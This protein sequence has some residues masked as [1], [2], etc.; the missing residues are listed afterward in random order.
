VIFSKKFKG[1]SMGN[2]LSVAV[3]L[4]RKAGKTQLD[5]LG[6]VMTIERKGAINLVTEVDRMCEKQIFEGLQNAFPQHDVLGEEGIAKRSESEFRWIVDPLDGTT[7][8][9]HQFPFFGVSIAL[10]H[11]GEIICGVVYDPTREDIFAAEKGKGTTLNGKPVRV[12]GA[13]NLK[14]SLLATGFAYNVQ[15]EDRLDNLDN[16]ANFIKT[17]LAVRRPGAAAIDLA[18][19]ACGRL[20]GFWELFLKPWDIAAGVLLIREAGGT[21]T[22]FNGSTFDVY[23]D[24]IL[25]SN[26]K[27]HEEMI[28]V[29]KMS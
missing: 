24:E 2:Y 13:P 17:A 4:A 29:L 21:V 15:E 27:I 14:E 11:K 9:A 5:N 25:A 6:R 7:N 28:K 19:V 1:F 23:G 18:Y 20:D 8:Y 26:G 22:S 16:F 12:S 3:D 10:E